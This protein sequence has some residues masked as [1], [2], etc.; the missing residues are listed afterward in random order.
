[1]PWQGEVELQWPALGQVVAFSRVKGMGIDFSKLQLAPVTLRLRSGGESLRPHAKAANRSLKH[2]LQE[3]RIPPWLRE[4]LP[5]LYC[6]DELV[7]VVGVAVSAN[8]Q[9]GQNETGLM[10]S[11]K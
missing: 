1:M 5:L 6:G 4:R 9:A 7:S 3:H 10:V 8:F 2:L 11:C